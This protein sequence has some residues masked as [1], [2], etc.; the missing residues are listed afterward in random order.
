MYSWK[1]IHWELEPPRR[2]LPSCS[3][4]QSL[5]RRQET[6][7][8]RQDRRTRL[9]SHSDRFFSVLGLL[10]GMAGSSVR[11]GEAAALILSNSSNENRSF[12]V[13]IGP[14]LTATE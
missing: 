8:R 6:L 10:T 4:R 3:A 1:R 9:P 2:S 11:E 12:F 14:S 5:P 13:S 7:M